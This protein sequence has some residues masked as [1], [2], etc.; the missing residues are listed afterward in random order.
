MK[1]KN[2]LSNYI[3]K[4]TSFIFKK[5]DKIRKDSN[6]FTL[7]FNG[8]VIIFSELY[9]ILI[10]L[11]TYLLISEKDLKAERFDKDEIR[12]YKLRKRI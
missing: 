3:L 10:S 8:I 9:L 1:L 4:I 12:S 2:T 6:T 11:P 5:K 7:M